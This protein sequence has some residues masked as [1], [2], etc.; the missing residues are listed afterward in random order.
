MSGTFPSDAHSSARFL[1]TEQH[2]LELKWKGSIQD[3]TT[4]FL[5]HWMESRLEAVDAHSLQKKRII[6]VAIELLQNMHHH[7]LVHDTQPEFAVYSTP[8]ITWRIEASNAIDHRCVKELQETW[9]KLKSKCQNELR[10][11]QRD[12]L[13]GDSRSEH[14]GGGV[15]LN[16]ILRKADGQVDMNI[17]N[18]SEVACVTF[19]AE[20]PLQS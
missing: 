20:I 1:P 5:M 17:E 2:A 3:Q 11:M 12:K 7:A 15:G 4:D 19:S 8:S 14:G 13:A 16:E 9:T 6:R 18:R 10:S